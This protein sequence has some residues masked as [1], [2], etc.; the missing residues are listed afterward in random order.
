M[1]KQHEMEQNLL[2][3]NIIEH[4]QKQEKEKLLREKMM[5]EE[6]LQETTK[7]VLDYKA[8]INNL[9]QQTKVENINRAT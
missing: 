3:L 2:K 5:L 9:Q 6:R 4:Q 7:N 8:Y 1:T